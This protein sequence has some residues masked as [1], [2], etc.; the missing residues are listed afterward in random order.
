MADFWIVSATGYMRHA[1]LI[2]ATR[3]R[4]RLF[5]QSPNGHFRIY[6]CKT[7]LEPSETFRPMGNLLLEAHDYIVDEAMR[8][9]IRALLA[10]VGFFEE[11]TV[12]P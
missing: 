10:H 9:R 7:R 1:S 8:L 4:T 5:K 11:D 3:E 6:H 12:T 2:G